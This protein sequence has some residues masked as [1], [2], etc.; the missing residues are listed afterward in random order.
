MTKFF[1]NG[2]ACFLGL[3]MALIAF[4]FSA[5]AQTTAPVDDHDVHVERSGNKF[6]VDMVAHAPVSANRA[7][8]VLTD[9]EHMP[10]FVNNLTSSQVLERRPDYLRVSQK[11]RGD[12]GPFARTFESERE[13]FLTP[14]REIRAQGT[15]VGVRRMQSLMKIDTEPDGVRLT[16]HAE[17]EPDFWMPPLIGPAFVR[18]ETAEQFSAMIREMLR[19]Q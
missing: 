19:R 15:G 17:V 12:F 13:I 1:K 7:W 10:A 2:T 16:Y 9:F 3:L 8:D 14:Q 18:H 5:I 6:T 11:G 4:S